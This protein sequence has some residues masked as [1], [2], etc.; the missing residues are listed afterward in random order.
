MPNLLSSSFP[1]KAFMGSCASNGISPHFEHLLFLYLSSKG[2]QCIGKAH[3]LESV[4]L[5]FVQW[6]GVNN[7][8]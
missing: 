8:T 7:F 1:I 3:H 2:S 5:C 6:A 4:M